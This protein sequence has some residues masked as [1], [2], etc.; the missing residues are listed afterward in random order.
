MVTYAIDIVTQTNAQEFM[1]N[2]RM[3]LKQSPKSPWRQWQ[4]TS[5]KLQ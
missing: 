3:V 5:F 4:A 1:K 2:K